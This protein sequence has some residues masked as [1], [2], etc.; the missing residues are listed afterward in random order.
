L[1][2]V[3]FTFVFF[4]GMHNVALADCGK[5]AF[6]TFSTAAHKVESIPISPETILPV[7]GGGNTNTRIA[8]A[9]ALYP[10]TRC[11][12]EPDTLDRA[13]D[14]LVRLWTEALKSTNSV[15]TLALVRAGTTTM[16]RACWGVFTAQVRADA[17]SGY[18]LH[19]GGMMSKY[20]LDER[21]GLAAMQQLPAYPHVHAL[22]VGITHAL[23]MP[24]PAPGSD[25]QPWLYGYTNASS[26]AAAH[27][28]TGTN[29]NVLIARTSPQ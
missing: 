28:P 10:I 1:L 27:L 29:C 19:A 5:S 7:V 26:A 8:A 17:A 24:L 18:A 16:P 11:P 21:P 14:S 6:A 9:S 12:D 4:A 3:A 23:A 20:D 2:P 13:L 22:W 25:M 15:A